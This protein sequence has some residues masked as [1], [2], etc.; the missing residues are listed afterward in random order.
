MV[1]VWLQIL[2]SSLC[3]SY[4]MIG[5]INDLED[6]VWTSTKQVWYNEFIFEYKP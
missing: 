1:V 3:N 5:L 2:N 4:V 6:V